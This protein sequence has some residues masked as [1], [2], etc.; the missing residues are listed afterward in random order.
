MDLELAGKVALVTGATRGIGRATARALAREG[1]RVAILAR[2]EKALEETANE[3]RAI[4]AQTLPLQADLALDH[5]VDRA[6]TELRENLGPPSILVLAAASTYRIRKL[7]TIDDA[8]ARALLQTDLLSA[9]RLVRRTVADM[10]LGGFG[11]I[12]VLGSVAARSGVAG[13]TLY[14][15]AKAGL[16]G[17]V[18][19]V[20]VDY[21]RRGITANVVNVGVAETER[22]A[23]RVAGDAEHRERLKRATSTR[24]LTDPEDIANVVC[25]LA[26]RR[27]AA[28]TGAVV[29]AT[30][31]AHLNNLW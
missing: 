28:I 29:D 15:L 23:A 11:R 1:A 13:G 14:G 20:T 19:G 5:S 3:L 31:G 12:V 7:H 17:L 16:E 21:A 9:E 25:F 6:L 27:A 24:R 18:R 2:G 22:I 26:S 30:S 4:G 10:M 8:E